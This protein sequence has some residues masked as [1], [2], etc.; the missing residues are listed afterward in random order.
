MAAGFE[1]Q[2]IYEVVYRSQDP[3]V[4]GVGPAAV[5]DTVSRL[6]YGSRQR[7]WPRRG[8]D[9]A[10][11]RLRHLTERPVPAHVS[12]LRVQRR[13]V[14][15]QGVRRRHGARGGQRPRQLQS[16]LRAAVARRASVHQLLLSDR[17][18][19]VHRRASSAT[20]K[21][22]SRDGLLTHATKPAFQPKVF[23]TNSSYEYWGRAA[24][25][26]HTTVDGKKDAPL[27]AERARVS[28]DRRPARRRRRSRRR[29][30]SASR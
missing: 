30:A 29:A 14:A 26:F 12:L 24:S 7:A 15:P 25:L 1:P 19:S 5:R 21:P 16:S 17:H 4:V 3:P 20:R 23:Y 27:A 2:K 6:K 11:D 13:R 18:L 9:Q 8:R 28:P 10:R 22:A